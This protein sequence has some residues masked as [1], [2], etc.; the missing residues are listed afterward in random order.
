MAYLKKDKSNKPD[1]RNGRVVFYLTEEDHQEFTSMANKLG[2]TRSSLTT[3]I[4]ERLLLGGFSPVV[5]AKLCYQ[6]QSLHEKRGYPLRGMYF[7]IRPLPPLAEEEISKRETK[8]LLT[9]IK[10]ELKLC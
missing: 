8:S 9:Q 5:G 2:L 10:N 7:G 3:S 4:I 1:L 6:I